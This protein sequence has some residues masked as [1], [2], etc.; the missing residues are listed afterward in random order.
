MVELVG[1]YKSFY[2]WHRF[3]AAAQQRLSVNNV[4]EATAF[5]KAKLY[6]A[7][8]SCEEGVVAT[9]GYVD[10]RMKLGATLTNDDR[11]ALQNFTVV[12]LDAKALT[13]GISAVPCR[14]ATLSL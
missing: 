11:S 10:P 3:S 2:S 1:R 6:F 8:S 4:D 12:G 9:L 5:A 7:R 13:S 14:T